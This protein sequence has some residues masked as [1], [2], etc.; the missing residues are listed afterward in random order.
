MKRS[1]ISFLYGY[2]VCSF[3]ILMF[4]FLGQ[5]PGLFSFDTLLLLQD[6]QQGRFHSGWN[7][8]IFS[9]IVRFF[10]WLTPDL[11]SFGLFNVMT[12]SGFISFAFYWFIK[13]KVPVA[14]VTFFFAW[15][16]YTP[17]VGL[18]MMS[19]EREYFTVWL[20]L[21]SVLL[22]FFDL[23]KRHGSDLEVSAFSFVLLTIVVCAFAMIKQDSILA[24]PTFAFIYYLNAKSKKRFLTQC[25]PLI[26]LFGILI[27]VIFPLALRAYPVSP[28][29]LTTALV[30]PIKY[31]LQNVDHD[32]MKTE[33]LANISKII[34]ISDLIEDKNFNDIGALWKK[35]KHQTA[36]LKDFRLFIQSSLKLIVSHPALFIKERGRLFYYAGGF[37]PYNKYSEDQ[38][39][40]PEKNRRLK[41]VLKTGHI[42]KRPW[43]EKTWL[44]FQ[45]RWHDFHSNST[46]FIPHIFFSSLF[47]FLMAL[48][49]FTFL[50]MKYKLNYTAAVLL[51]IGSKYFVVFA[52]SPAAYYKYYF[53]LYVLALFL[54]V[55]MWSEV[56]LRRSS[57]RQF[58]D[59]KK[60]E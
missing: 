13:R 7:S 6:I 9:N 51:F 42:K 60:S 59:L 22:I 28:I 41:N 15:L 2:L 40:L 31:I 45:L 36:S 5:K 1:N 57:S 14:I 29:Y 35:G 50:Y 20:G 34:S 8:Y 16:L 58:T 47:P 27:N 17:H 21:L 19:Y 30:N 3:L 48:V 39:M 56:I 53:G 18:F 4:W 46:F 37:G 10:Y 23:S 26:F 38:L 12:L 43:P 54:P 44:S 24:I 55:M 25:L 11:S 33:E 32:Q 49:A 52:C